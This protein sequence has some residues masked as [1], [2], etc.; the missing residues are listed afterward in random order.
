MQG[1]KKALFWVV[2]ALVLLFGLL[3]LV[4]FLVPDKPASNFVYD[5][6]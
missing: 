6:F 1:W 4:D 2:L 5:G 3:L